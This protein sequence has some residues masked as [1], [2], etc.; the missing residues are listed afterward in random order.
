MAWVSWTSSCSKLVN[1]T[2]FSESNT[3]TGASSSSMIDFSL[4]NSSDYFSYC[5]KR[6]NRHFRDCP[7]V[8]TTCFL[9]K[10][11]LLEA[12]IL[13]ELELDKFFALSLKEALS[14]RYL[15][16]SIRLLVRETY[17]VFL[18]SSLLSL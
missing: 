14:L 4:R 10:R 1:C 16:S 12:F 13:T 2:I 11:A 15:C 7:K 8:Y 3:K 17:S 18:I 6:L 9:L 5:V